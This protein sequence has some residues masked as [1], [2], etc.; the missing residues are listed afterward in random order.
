M[1]WSHT[2]CSK[3]FQCFNQTRSEYLL[4]ETI[5]HRSRCKRIILAHQPLRK[6]QSVKRCVDRK[7]IERFGDC[8]CY[9]ISFRKETSTN[10]HVCRALLIGH[11]LHHDRCIL[12]LRI[13][14]L[15][16]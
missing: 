15:N 10:E 4:P 5:H 14:Q 3:V 1:C 8:W 7:W 12:C 11:F 9:H 2:L 16:K 6:S 13:D